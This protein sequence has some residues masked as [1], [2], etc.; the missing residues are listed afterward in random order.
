MS[1]THGFTTDRNV[2]PTGPRAIAGP[3]L[4]KAAQKTSDSGR[5]PARSVA[6][7]PNEKRGARSCSIPKI[8]PSGS[9]STLPDRPDWAR[10]P[11]WFPRTLKSTGEINPKY[12]GGVTKVKAMLKREGHSLV[13][14]G[15]RFFVAGFE[16][17]LAPLHA[18]S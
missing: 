12:P 3:Q 18:G 4:Q 6:W 13:R 16:S 8:Y 15:E 11:A 10:A 17:N 14:K 9:R 7:Q 5:M 1:S 2:C